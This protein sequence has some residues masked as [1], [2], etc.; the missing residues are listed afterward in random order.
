MEMAILMWRPLQATDDKVSWY[1]NNGN[2]SFTKKSLATNVPYPESIEG[3]DIDGDGIM[4]LYSVCKESH[5]V[6]LYIKAPAPPPPSLSTC[7]DLFI[8][9]YI[10]GSASNKAIEIYNATGADIDLSNL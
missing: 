10:E 2:Q 5:S 7:G 1:E 4:D 9:E 3:G 6:A 8:S